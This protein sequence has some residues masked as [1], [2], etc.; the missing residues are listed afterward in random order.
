MLH[1]ASKADLIFSKL[2]IFNTQFSFINIKYIILYNILCSLNI[3]NKWTAMIKRD[4]NE[5]T[6]NKCIANISCNA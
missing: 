6:L 1:K 3:R 5:T 4:N 2:N